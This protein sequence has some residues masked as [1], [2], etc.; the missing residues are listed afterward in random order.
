MNPLG[1]FNTEYLG[2][3]V[4]E[5]AVL[6]HN[7]QMKYVQLDPRVQEVTPIGEALSSNRARQVRAILAAHDIQIA[8][9]A[10]YTN[11]VD[12]D[13]E[14]RKRGL[15]A[16]EEMIA[17]CHDYGTRYIATETGSLNPNSPWEDDPLNHTDEAWAQLMD[18]LHRLAETARRHE[19]TIL[20]EG[21]IV[22][23]LSTIEQAEKLSKEFPGDEIGFVLDPF[24]Y[25][26]CE[27]INRPQPLLEKVF[28]T[29]A[30][31]SPIAHAKD[32]ACTP[33]GMDTPKAGAGSMDWIAYAAL[34]KQHTPDVPLILEHLKRP[35]IPACKQFVQQA[36]AVK[37]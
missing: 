19:V 4:E 32:V 18:V 34:L 30:K 36:F 27:D 17:L 1:V 5:M 23:V 37:G 12:P 26:T 16:F 28:T 33:S 10:G 31:R 3:S 21:S 22:N 15:Q 6:I 24:N 11:L 20:I 2:M 9:L 35:D 29:I 14:Q 25:F 7:E 8:A 13:L